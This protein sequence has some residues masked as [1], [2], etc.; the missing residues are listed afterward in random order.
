[1]LFETANAKINWALEVTGRREDGYHLLDMLMQPVSL[2][3]ELSAEEADEIS[4]EI[5]GDPIAPGPEN[6]IWR[7]AV[8][9]RSHAGIIKG[10]HIVL[11]KRIPS[12]AGLGGGSADCAA[13]LRLLRRLWQID[14]SDEE[15]QGIGLKLGADVP[16]C[17][18]NRFS[19]VQGIGETVKPVGWAKEIALV[20]LKPDEGV[21]TPKAFRVLDETFQQKPKRDL[22]SALNALSNGDWGN[23]ARYAGNDL[24]GPALQ[25]VPRIG[26]CIELL[27]KHGALYADMSG[28]GSA[29][30]G[31]FADMSK[32]QAAAKAIGPGAYAAY[33]LA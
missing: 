33:T 9:L 23:F 13:A 2:C 30:F 21:P 16:F 32:A 17:L 22:D 5:E 15:L 14:V 4:L 25:I 28:S 24:L 11:K 6:L 26:E 1:M 8:A 3:D 31:V 7:A 12:Q 29:V 18:I 20:I 10:A 27:K 19:R